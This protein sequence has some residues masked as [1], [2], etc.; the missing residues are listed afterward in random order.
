MD[1]Y[2][3]GVKNKGDPKNL[4]DKGYSGSTT[5][6][7]GKTSAH[8]LPSESPVHY[9]WDSLSLSREECIFFWLSLSAQKNQK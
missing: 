8:V 9:M 7:D 3:L 6:F 1:L 4:E 2:L 5:I